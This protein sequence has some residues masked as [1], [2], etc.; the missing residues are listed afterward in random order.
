M[1]DSLQGFAG[2]STFNSSQGGCPEILSDGLQVAGVAPEI[3]AAIAAAI[4]TYLSISASQFVINSV[5]QV[6]PQNNS[7][8]WTGAGKLRLIEKR[9]DIAILRRRKY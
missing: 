1:D 7:S 5:K 9:Q 8:F 2:T 3:V 4:S 6:P